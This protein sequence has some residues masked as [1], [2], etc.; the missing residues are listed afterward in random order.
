MSA[1]SFWRGSSARRSGRRLLIPYVRPASLSDTRR[2]GLRRRSAAHAAG[3]PTGASRGCAA[4]VSPSVRCPP[5]RESPSQLLPSRSGASPAHQLAA[6]VLRAGESHGTAGT[7]SRAIEGTRP[8]FIWP[9]TGLYQRGC[10]PATGGGY[11][12]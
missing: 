4:A 9:I 1:A 10:L 6:G 12:G 3:G 7:I 11:V 8:A 5:A 2:L